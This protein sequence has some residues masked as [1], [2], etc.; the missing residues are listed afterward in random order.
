M[1]AIRIHEFGGPEQLRCEDAPVPQPG[2]GQVL[3][4]VKA[5]SVNPIDWKLASGAMQ[6]FR[7]IELPWIPGGDFAGVVEAVGPGVTNVNTG[8]QVYG[9]TP[10]GGSYAELVAASADMIA[11]QPPK[12]TAVEAAS[13]P[14]AGQTAWQA[15]FDHGQLQ[16]GQTILVH[17]AAGGV[18]G[19]A[20]QFARWKGAR[21]L[22]TAS[23]E[24]EEYVRTLGADVVIDYRATRFESVARDVDL[25]LD[26]IGGDTQERSFDCTQARRLSNQHRAGAVTGG[27]G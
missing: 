16:A 17:G 22:A 6:A 11:S 27:R 20:V 3:V 15:I 26:L 9:D 18:G 2:E 14:L 12:L 8:D 23:A 19:Y 21:V 5:A 7:P 24:D 1:K 25:V 13:L 10:S 4:R